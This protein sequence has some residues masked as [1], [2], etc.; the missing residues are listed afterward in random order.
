MEN[1]L[2]NKQIIMS[3][4]RDIYNILEVKPFVKLWDIKSNE[5]ITLPVDAMIIISQWPIIGEL[6][7]SP[8]QK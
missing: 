2:V 8:N 6:I 4:D 3:P 1:F 7:C 5:I